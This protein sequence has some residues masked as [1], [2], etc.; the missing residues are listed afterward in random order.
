LLNITEKFLH[1]EVPSPSSH[2]KTTSLFKVVIRFHTGTY[3][4]AMGAFT[5][6]F[7]SVEQNVILLLTALKRG[8]LV[9]SG[10]L[11]QS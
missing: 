4:I 5:A 3:F 1:R 2:Q 10:L 7:P 9:L 8:P 6:A 11:S